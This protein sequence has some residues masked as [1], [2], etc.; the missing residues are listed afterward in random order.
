M[1]LLQLSLLG[2]E[3]INQMFDL[4]FTTI[5]QKV[6]KATIKKQVELVATVV[7][8]I[9][10]AFYAYKDIEKLEKFMSG[11][12]LAEQEVGYALLQEMVA[13]AETSMSRRKF[14]LHYFGEEFDEI[15]GDGA[16]MDDN[17]RNP[18]PK[19]EAQQDVSMLL[20]LVKETNEQVQN[21][22]VDTHY[23]RHRNAYFSIT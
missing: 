13:Y 10:L 4:L 7:K 12:P 3:S 20:N 11:K 1:S 2:W 19:V 9:V 18:K 21:Q 23:G 14:I 15:N 5:S 17:T 8:D 6:L 16:E 22:R